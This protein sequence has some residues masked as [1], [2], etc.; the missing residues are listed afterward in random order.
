[1]IL[2]LDDEVVHALGSNLYILCESLNLKEKKNLSLII[3]IHFCLMIKDLDLLRTLAINS[4]E[5]IVEDLKDNNNDEF[6]QFIKLV[7][8]LYF[9]SKEADFYKYLSK[10]KLLN[11]ESIKSTQNNIINEEKEKELLKEFFV[12]FPF[13]PGKLSCCLLIPV[14]YKNSNDPSQTSYLFFTLS[15]LIKDENKIIQKQAISCLFSLLRNLRESLVLH[16]SNQSQEFKLTNHSLLIANT[17][18]LINNLLDKDNDTK[19]MLSDCVCEIIAIFYMLENI[20]CYDENE[21]L[22]KSIS[23][24]NRRNSLFYQD[25]INNELLVNNSNSNNLVGSKSNNPSK[26]VNK[27]IGKKTQILS[28]LSTNIIQSPSIKLKQSSLFES[29]IMNDSV[30]YSLV[31]YEHSNDNQSEL[32]NNNIKIT[33]KVKD[34]MR[35]RMTEMMK[36]NQSLET[37]EEQNN[38]YMTKGINS[39]SVKKAI[40]KKDT[41]QT[42]RVINSNEIISEY[43]LQDFLVIYLDFLKD[44]SWKIR[45]STLKVFFKLNSYVLNEFIN[46]LEFKNPYKEEH[47]IMLEYKKLKVLLTSLY[48]GFHPLL[49]DEVSLVKEEGFNQLQLLLNLFVDINENTHVFGNNSVEVKKCHYYNTSNLIKIN[50]ESTKSLSKFISSICLRT[51]SSINYLTLNLENNNNIKT[52]ICNILPLITK[53]LDYELFYDNSTLIIDY[54]IKDKNIMVKLSFT[55]QL[56]TLFKIGNESLNKRKKVLQTSKFQEYN[57]DLE[58]ISIIKRFFDDKNSR[59]RSNILIVT[60]EFGLNYGENIFNEYFS[61]Y[62][63]LYLTDKSSEVREKGLNQLRLLCKEFNNEDWIIS[64]SYSKLLKILKTQNDKHLIR[65]TVVRSIFVFCEFLKI[66]NIKLHFLQIICEFVFDPLANIR[67]I[68]IRELFSF[69]KYVDTNTIELIKSNLNILLHGEIINDVM[70]SDR[71]ENDEDVKFLAERLI[72]EIGKLIN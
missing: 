40:L 24:N 48:E 36:V 18:D 43:F 71:K 68:T 29:N 44:E 38:E 58:H 56:F 21:A 11:K 32:S 16:K 42:T 39:P 61:E 8:N 17:I 2:F 45:I 14:I 46:K 12:D 64:I 55:N 65:S 22:R 3:D 60:S 69:I 62:F 28:L 27:K 49:L 50:N 7:E 30:N 35:S 47:E 51:L 37:I 13:L 72:N 23:N 66:D 25:S 15:K 4:I 6:K 41:C 10:T 31:S 34:S 57:R 9:I 54:L 33:P 67:L 59:V 26:V 5:R 52:S 70:I 20:D 19:K 53:L 63:F 1:M